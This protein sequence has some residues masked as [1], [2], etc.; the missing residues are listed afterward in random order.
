VK[1]LSYNIKDAA[2]ACGLSRS[3][4]D[5]AIRTGQLKAKRSAAPDGETGKS[6]GSYVIKATDLEAFIDSLADA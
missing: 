3:Y 2:V 6:R 5:R 4:L 1:P